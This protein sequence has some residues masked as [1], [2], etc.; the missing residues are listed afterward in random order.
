MQVWE[1]ELPATAAERIVR[2]YESSG[3]SPTAEPDEG[4]ARALRWHGH[5]RTPG[6]R[7]SRR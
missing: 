6:D 1:H 4:D 2:V 5:E 3:A 7:P